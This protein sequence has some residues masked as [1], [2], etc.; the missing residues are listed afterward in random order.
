MKTGTTRS[1]YSRRKDGDAANV[2]IRYDQKRENIRDIEARTIRKDGTIVPYTGE[3][4]EKPLAAGSEKKVLAKS[5]ALTEGEVGSIVE[6]RYSRRIKVGTFDIRW[7]LTNPLFTREARYSFKAGWP[8]RYSSPRGLPPG[9]APLVFDKKR[10]R[11]YLTTNNVTAFVEEEFSPRDPIP[12]SPGFHPRR[13]L[14]QAREGS[15]NVLEDL[16][17]RSAQHDA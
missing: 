4:F 9:T 13:G 6:Y 12:V 15:G 10:D 16:C 7:M 14:E 11:V 1:R 2:E 17:G 5:L 8:T 3:I